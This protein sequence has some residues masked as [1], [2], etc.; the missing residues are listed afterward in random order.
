[1]KNVLV[2]TDAAPQDKNGY[3]T[4]SNMHCRIINSIRELSVYTMYITNQPIKITDHVIKVSNSS[5]IKKAGAVVHGYPPYLNS[6][7]VKSILEVL[8]EKSISIVYIDNSISGRLIKKI[9]S[10]F[11]DISV[12]SFFHDVNPPSL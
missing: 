12:V 1:M 10:R 7:A 9:K 4:N 8:Q 5:K 2:I 3:G 11:S 6:R